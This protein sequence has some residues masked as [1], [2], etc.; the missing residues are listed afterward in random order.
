MS[1]GSEPGAEVAALTRS[2]GFWVI[3]KYAALFG[4]VLPFAALAFLGLVKGGTNAWFTL[5]KTPGWL[6]GHLWWVG[7]TAGA[8]V[9][10]GL[11][12]RAFRLPPKLPGTI[13]DMRA[14]RVEPASVPGK[15][16]VSVLSLAGGASL[17]PEAAL[18]TMGGGLGT[19]VSER[20]GL[21]EDV[22]A[23]NTLS[24][25]SGAYG[26]LLSAP[27]IATLL[28]LEGARPKATRAMDMVTG[29]LLASSI[30]FAIYF[31]IAGSTF[32]GLYT[33]PPA[34]YADWQLLAAVPLGLVAGALAL[35]TA[36]A[37]GV[38][39]KLTAPIANR[40]ILRSTIGGSRSDS[41][42]SRCR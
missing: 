22:R 8:G 38:M 35:I 34:K 12:R 23:T 11:V 25:M 40:T 18:G 33:L 5:P 36:V 24:G 20:R 26:A 39:T 21:D 9:L 4:V 32:I 6:D 30:A 29:G 42:A 16:A 7:V 27:Y 1:A 10:V 17:G 3:V 13:E 15:V 14:E 28:I 41:S 19:W 37:I 2:P 31:P